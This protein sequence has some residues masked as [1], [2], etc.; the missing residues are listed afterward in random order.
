MT[1]LITVWDCGDYHNHIY[2]CARQ[3]TNQNAGLFI[4]KYDFYDFQLICNSLHYVD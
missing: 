3:E 2:D 4:Y 1:H